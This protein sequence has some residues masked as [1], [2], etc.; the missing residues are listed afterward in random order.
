MARILIIVVTFAVVLLTGCG[1]GGGDGGGSS[2]SG[3]TITTYRSVWINASWSGGATG[4]PLS[5]ETDI[6]T[7][8]GSYCPPA[9]LDLQNHS[10]KYQS[11]FSNSL[12]TLVFKNA[13]TQS[14]SL[15]VCVT[16]GSGGN[17]SDFPVCNVDPRTTPL[18]RLMVIS[19]G[20]NSSGVQSMTWVP[21]GVNLDVNIFYCGVGDTFTAGA[22]SGTN[23]TDCI[24]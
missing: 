1:G 15:L 14:A 10:S 16:A 4:S 24:Q 12:T 20:P 13:C 9:S 23:P 18:S 2:G 22:I 6:P 19:L 11:V 3:P 17:F 7:F 8:N 5:S 21:T